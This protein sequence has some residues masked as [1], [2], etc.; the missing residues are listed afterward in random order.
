MR[1]VYIIYKKLNGHIVVTGRVDR[2]IPPDGSTVPEYIA[3]KLTTNPDLAVEY[4]TNQALPDIKLKKI[5][6]GNIVDMTEQEKKLAG[7][8]QWITVSDF[9]DWLTATEEE[10]LVG[11]TDNQVKKI[12]RKL[13]LTEKMDRSKNRVIST[14]NYL[15]TAG[16]IGPGRAAEFL[17]Y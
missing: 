17:A 16:V 10:E 5:T 13:M 4:K 11:S 3:N 15:E 8:L 1:E 12:R 6:D 7:G 14:I 9:R 2:S